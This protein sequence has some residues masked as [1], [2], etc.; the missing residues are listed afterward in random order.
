MQGASNASMREAAQRL[1]ELTATAGPDDLT[2]IA[3]EL[4]AVSG[5]LDS[6]V[7]LRRAASDP[8]RSP[9]DR[10][11]L[12]RGLLSGQVSGATADIVSGV[13]R[14]RWSAPRDLV[15]ATESLAAQGA[16]GAA[17]RSG[18]LDAVED[19]LFRFR[20]IVDGSVGLRTALT[21]PTVE[22]DRKQAL[23][24][25]LL[26][27][28]VAPESQLL[29]R[30]AFVSLRGRGFDRVLES[31]GEIAAQRRNRL[32]ASVVVAAPLTEDQR[33]RLAGALARIY[34]REPH[35]DIEV[36]P[37]VV[38]GI[39]VAIGDEVIDGTVAT[40]LMV[41]RRAFAG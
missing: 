32:V 3:N 5:L 28:R 8:S 29:L 34:G 19:D 33:G 14:A 15:D 23:L 9:E 2:T 11:G 26:G 41:L 7:A 36:D 38:G 13:V 6:S 39:R 12:L 18:R 25:D 22:A 10:A 40:R 31:F 4:F 17:D 21:D 37:D 35:L 24:E 30:Q 27:D 16:V 1:E 20:R